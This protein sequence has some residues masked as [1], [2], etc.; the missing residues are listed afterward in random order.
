M[1]V[2]SGD[3][4]I[5][6]SGNDKGTTGEVKVALP[7]TQRV[8]IEG[9]NLRWK[10][11]KPTQQDPQGERIQTECSIHVSN[12]MHLDPETKKGVRRRPGQRPEKSKS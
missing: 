5:V 10:H 4:V 11:R 7:E 8:I 3:Q 12:V 9:V 2:R 6:I 1:H